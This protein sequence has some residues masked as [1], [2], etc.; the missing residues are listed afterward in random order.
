ML[1]FPNLTINLN[2][3][4]IVTIC[5]IRSN[6]YNSNYSLYRCN[7][8][9]SPSCDCGDPRQDINHILW[10]C[11]LLNDHRLTLFNSLNRLNFFLPFDVFKLLINPS[12]K[13]ILP[14]ISFLRKH[15][16]SI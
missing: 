13:I 16:L 8:V 3:F 12:Q 1:G 5:R 14:I 9:N 15:N 11:P 2:R 7:L 4:D 6:H 10:H